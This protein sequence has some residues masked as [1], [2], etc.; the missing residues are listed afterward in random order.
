M[1]NIAKKLSEGKVAFS[2]N[3]VDGTVRQAIGT[4]NAQYIPEADRSGIPVDNDGDKT[5]YFDLE[6]NA[7]RNF[8]TANIDESS[9]SVAE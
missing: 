4:T 3:K 9:I 1:S 2:Y 7:W 5:L 6:R 8:L